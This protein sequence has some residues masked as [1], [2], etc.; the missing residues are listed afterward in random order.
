[1]KFEKI[2][3]PPSHNQIYATNRSGFGRG[4]TKTEKYKNWEAYMQGW[5]LG[6]QRLVREAESVLG[7][8]VHESTNHFLTISI[9]LVVPRTDII[10]Q[11]DTIK[12]IDASNRIKPL[13]DALANIIQI[14]D[15]HFFLGS[16]EFIVH[17]KHS[18]RWADLTFE[19]SLLKTL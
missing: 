12:R 19:R 11:M 14:D 2:P 7:K 9:A 15:R 13:L 18:Y 3:Y 5:V 6:N 10:S 17:N 16:C 8:Y 4:K 1:M